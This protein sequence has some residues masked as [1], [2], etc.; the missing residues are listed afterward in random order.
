[1]QCP[2]WHP[3]PYMVHHSIHVKSGAPFEGIGCNLGCPCLK[4]SLWTY[5]PRVDLLF[6]AVLKQ[7]VVRTC[8]SWFEKHFYEVTAGA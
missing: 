7:V 1:M 5:C 2:K 4:G 8:F 3:I 6:C